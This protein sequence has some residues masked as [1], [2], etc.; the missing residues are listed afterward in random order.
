MR[1]AARNGIVL[2]GF[3]LAGLGFFVL[4]GAGSA[5]LTCNNQGFICKKLSTGLPD[6]DCPK[7]ITSLAIS[8]GGAA[9]EGWYDNGTQC[10]R[11]RKTG[12]PCGD[13][14]STMVCG[15]SSPPPPIDY[16]PSGPPDGGCD[17]EVDPFCN[18]N[19]NPFA[20]PVPPATG[21][22]HASTV[23]GVQLPPQ[24]VSETLAEVAD[25]NLPPAVDQLLHTLAGLSSVHIKTR[26]VIQ[27][28]REEGRAGA[29]DLTAYEY[30][31]AGTRY[32]IHAYVNPSVGLSQVPDFAFDGVHQQM[33]LQSGLE[34]TLSIISL[35]ARMVPVAIPN[36]L[37]LPLAF[38]SP[39]DQDRC[40]LCELRLADIATLSSLRSGKSTTKTSAGTPAT[41]SVRGW[42]TYDSDIHFDVQF[43]KSSRITSVRQLTADGKELD[44]TELSDYRKVLGAPFEFPRVID[45][46]R[47]APGAKAPWLVVRYIVDRLDVNQKI[48]DS[49]F[50]IP[51]DTVSK[52]WDSDTSQWR[53]YIGF[54]TEG[55]C[56]KP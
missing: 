6:L 56:K 26:V 38:L 18:E 42:R 14:L 44:V 46:K 32:R 11:S 45:F 7:A 36:P 35:D 8:N 13:K 20:S 34:R 15:V 23:G 31:E 55:F 47:S 21:A 51:E 4:C 12:D 41:L 54:N 10:G 50:V 22:S 1:R 17:Y 25:Q 3:V 49:T 43:D 37:F 33:V 19:Q 24:R 30:W 29:T 9:T 27:T 2:Q 39:N 52:V 53:K 16:P 40:P 28:A 48:A 5:V